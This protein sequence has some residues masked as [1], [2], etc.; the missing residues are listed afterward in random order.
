VIVFPFEGADPCGP[1]VAAPAGPLHHL[2]G[3]PGD[4]AALDGVPRV[5]LRQRWRAVDAG[6][7]GPG[8]MASSQS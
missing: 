3:A 1:G 8:M 5:H 2:C 4:P 6:A 7:P